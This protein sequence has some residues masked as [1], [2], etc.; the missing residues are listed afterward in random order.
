MQTD[1]DVEA[2][3][4]M[5]DPEATVTG[6]QWVTTLLAPPSAGGR[7]GAPGK[8]REQ[9]PKP[10]LLSGMCRGLRD[11]D[12]PASQL[13]SG[14]AAL[15]FFRGSPASAGCG[16]SETLHSLGESWSWG[17]EGTRGED[18]GSPFDFISKN[19]ISIFYCIVSFHII[20]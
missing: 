11:S 12:H 8:L 16:C 3:A 7:G 2:E 5:C 20:S 4:G 6:E 19:F 17:L 9:T 13:L 10:H 18:G 14:G 15:N 1:T